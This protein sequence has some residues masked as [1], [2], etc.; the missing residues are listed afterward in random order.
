MTYKLKSLRQYMII[1]LLAAIVGVVILISVINSQPTASSQT[2]ADMIAVPIVP[3]L[4]PLMTVTNESTRTPA[5]TMNAAGILATFAPV[6][7]R[8]PTP[9]W[10]S[11]SLLTHIVQRGDS[12]YRL[13]QRYNVPMAAIAATNDMT[14]TSLMLVGDRILIPVAELQ[15]ADRIRVLPPSAF[16]QSLVELTGSIL[17]PTPIPPDHVNGVQISE[18]IWMP[19]AVVEHVQD[20][21]VLGQVLGRDVHRFSRMGDSTIENPHFLTRF[22]SGP[23]DL[24]DYEYLQ[25]V[26]DHFQGSFALENVTIRRG[27]HTWSVFDPMWANREFCEPGEHM[28]ACELRLHN[29]SILIVRL[30]SNDR[31]MP[32]LTEES[33]RQVIEYSIE[34]G[35]I[36]IM[37]TKADRFDGPE[38]T[39]NRIIRELAREY[40]VPLWDYDRVAGTIPGRGLESDQV[41]LTAFYA[42][43]WTLERA[44]TR[45]HGLHNL[46]GL[47]SLDAVW[48]I[49]HDVP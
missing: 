37:G 7:T 12:L 23:Y 32:A 9:T 10:T 45:G 17:E 28:L 14:N 5:A 34:S 6:T 16:E 29:P 49:L 13:S 43:D 19:Q 46:T 27:L 30:G 4:A 21:Y 11:L 47:I 15:G 2:T 20:I 8:T 33:L 40:N 41:H 48:Q 36:P 25:P 38:N 39:T 22:D 1:L 31:R 26:I 18:F 42:H 24:G 3:T 35:V 44:F